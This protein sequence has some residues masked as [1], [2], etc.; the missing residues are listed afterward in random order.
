V[1]CKYKLSI[2]ISLRSAVNFIKVLLTAFT[3]ADQKTQKKADN[4]TVFF[5]LLGSALLK[6]ARKMLVKLTPGNCGKSCL[7]TQWILLK[8]DMALR[9]KTH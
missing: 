3:Q 5:G 4:L 9:V 6:P 7:K 2:K 1:D 8:W